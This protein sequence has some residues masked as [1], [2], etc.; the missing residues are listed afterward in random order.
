MFSMKPNFKCLSRFVS[1]L[2][3]GLGLGVVSGSLHAFNIVMD[4]EDGTPGQVVQGSCDKERG[5]YRFTEAAGYTVFTD[6]D[7]Y[8]EGQAARLS[9]DK[10]IGGFGKW[11]GIIGFQ[12]C[13]NEVLREGDEVWIRLRAKFPHNWMF[14]SGE[15]LKFLRLRAYSPSGSAMTYNDFQLN[16][17]DGLGRTFY[18]FHFI[19]EFDASKGW[20]LLG[21][22]EQYIDFEAWETYEVYFKINHITA[23]QDPVNGAR[24]V[25]WK[26]GEWVGQV[27]DR[28]T[29]PGPDHTIRDFYLFTWWNGRHGIGDAPQTQSMMIDD[30]RI[31]NERP[32]IRKDGFYTIGVGDELV[33]KSPQIIE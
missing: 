16:H 5:R 13:V 3:M 14:T 8:G 18:P 26:N 9:I 21:K 7:A 24:V 4:F 22:P 27:T 15:R 10:G 28:K 30:L 25:A 2:A 12:K 6:A 29:L 17:P 20:E 32:E 31:T 23:D 33:P 11:G 1:C 19:P